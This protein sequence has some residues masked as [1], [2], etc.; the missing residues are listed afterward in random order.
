MSLLKPHIPQVFDIDKILRDLPKGERWIRHLKDEL[1]PFWTM[2]EALG[3]PEGN[4]PTYRNNNGTLVDPVHPGPDFRNVID[5]I[6]WLDREYVRSKSRQCYAYGVGFHVTGDLRLL[7]YAKAGVKY[8][9]DNALDRDNGGAFTYLKNHKWLPLPKQRTSQDLAYALTGIGMLYYLTRDSDL[10]D[11]L[12]SVHDYIWDTYYD[13]QIGLVRWVLEP[14]PDGDAINQKELVAQLDQIYGYML[15]VTPALPEPHRSKWKGRLTKIAHIMMDQFYT[16]R[17]DMFWGAITSSPIKRWGTPHTDFGHSVKSFW[18]VS[19]IG[20]ITDDYEMFVSAVAR[21]AQ[22]LEWAYVERTGSWARAFAADGTLD[23][24][25]EWWICCELDQVAGALAL[26]DPA[27][28]R[29]LVKTSDYWLKYMVDHKHHEVWHMVSGAT[30]QPV[31]GYPKQHSWKNAL[32]S[33]E[34]AM[35]SYIFAQQLHG[36]NVKLHFAWHEQ[37]PVETIQ[38]YFYQGKVVEIHQSGKPGAT[39]NTQTVI[40]SDIH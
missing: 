34:H 2:P 33:F 8:L 35:V 1:L 22:I 11:D 37:P 3:N 10:L 36:E 31:A 16:P 39:N 5:G 24:D 23:E 38:P 4:F 27:Y 32:H 40:F 14:S 18:L 19:L 13:P 25:K 21:A 20:S 15:A 9:R 17:T 29:Y 26:A 6:A 28:A 12:L 7:E 30:N